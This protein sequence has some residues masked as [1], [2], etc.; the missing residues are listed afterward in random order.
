MSVL[1]V[2]V[3]RVSLLCE[4][5]MTLSPTSLIFQGGWKDVATDTHQGTLLPKPRNP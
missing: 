3:E 4:E 2:S 5:P 1:E